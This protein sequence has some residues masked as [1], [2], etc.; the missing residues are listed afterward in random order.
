MNGLSDSVRRQGRICA[1]LGSPM[2]GELLDRIADDIDA[3]GPFAELLAGHEALNLNRGGI[4]NFSVINEE[5][6]ART[7]FTVVAVPGL[8]PDEVFFTH[9]A[10]RRFPAGHLAEERTLLRVQALCAVLDLPPP[11]VTLCLAFRQDLH[12]PPGGRGKID[13]HGRTGAPAPEPEVVTSQWH[14]DRL[15]LGGMG[16][17]PLR[18]LQL[19]PADSGHCATVSLDHP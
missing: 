16:V 18:R 1:R 19:Q 11:K 17:L 12:P 6:K 10:N 8:V 4:P 7:G 9:L 15:D 3:G 2:Y 5:L 13:R 14:Q